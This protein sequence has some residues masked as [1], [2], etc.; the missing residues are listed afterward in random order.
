MAR[1]C[2]HHRYEVLA[3]SGCDRWACVVRVEN[4][5]PMRRGKLENNHVPRIGQFEIE[6]QSLAR[7]HHHVVVVLG[8]VPQPEPGVN[9]ILTSSGRRGEHN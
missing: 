2:T 5:K 9:E 6:R 1:A 8:R 3:P 7:V 4:P